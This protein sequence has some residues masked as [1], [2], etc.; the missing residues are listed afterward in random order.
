MHFYL[1]YAMFP[2]TLYLPLLE[3]WISHVFYCGQIRF[4]QKNPVSGAESAL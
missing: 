1:L 4:D 3:I 2:H